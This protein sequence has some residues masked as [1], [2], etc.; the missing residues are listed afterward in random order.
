MNV[1]RTHLRGTEAVGE[2]RLRASRPAPRRAALTAVLVVLVLLLLAADAQAYVPGELIWAQ[3]I[4][5][6]TNQA[7]ARDMACGPKGA[8]AIAGAQ[9]VPPT[10]GVPMVAKYTAAGLE[11]VRTYEGRGEAS[12]VEFD[13]A[14]NVYVAASVASAQYDYD[15]V[16]IKYDG[17]G[18][19]QWATRYGGG[20]GDQFAL[21]IAVDKSGDVIVVGTT[22]TARRFVKAVVVLKYD[23]N[24]ALAWPAAIYDPTDDPT[25]AD[26]TLR[27][28]EPSD[29]ALDT[30]GDVYVSGTFSAFWYRGDSVT[31]GLV[32]KFAG[33]DGT[34]A[35]RRILERRPETGSRL[36]SIAVRGSS[37]VAAGMSVD[38]TD[39]GGVADVHGLVASFDLDLQDASLKV[40]DA[41]DA[42]F[43]VFGDVVLDAKGNVYVTGSQ[44]SPGTTPSYSQAVTLKLDPSLSK[45]F[46]QATYAPESKAADSYLIAR[47]ADGDIYVAGVQRTGTPADYSTSDS[48]DFLTIKYGRSGEREWLGTW[49]GGGPGYEGPCGLVLGTK[50][51]VFVGGRA[52]SADGVPQAALLRYRE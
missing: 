40:W 49:S 42:I 48:Q 34:L 8:V 17:D 44:V 36:S 29:I 38:L 45:V 13:R 26:A 46:W 37:V 22:D 32:L 39:Y 18:V 1:V 3:G 27:L 12:A 6:S 52:W 21:S 51:D 25:D 10:G 20:G 5:T 33:A 35:A 11:W 23:A 43:E 4:G 9:N 24:G 47:G 31:S 41:D 30:A 7:G 28:V 15:I 50:R 19:Q 2:G 14:G 16:L